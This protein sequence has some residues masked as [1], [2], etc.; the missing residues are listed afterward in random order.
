MSIIRTVLNE[1]ALITSFATFGQIEEV[2]N[3]LTNLFTY[4]VDMTAGIFTSRQ[5]YI[6]HSYNDNGNDEDR[7]IHFVRDHLDPNNSALF[8]YDKSNGNFRLTNG[9]KN[10]DLPLYMGQ[11]TASVHAVRLDQMP[12][13]MRPYNQSSPPVRVDATTYSMTTVKVPAHD[14][15]Y[16]LQASNLNANI[17]NVGAG[18][19]ASTTTLAEGLNVHLY[20]IAKSNGADPVLFWSHRDTDNGENLDGLPA[21]YNSIKYHKLP[22]SLRVNASNQLPAVNASKGWPWAP[23]L[24]F[25]EELPRLIDQGN[26]TNSASP[27]NGDLTDV[28]PGNA[29]SVF[30]EIE[31]WSNE[32]STHTAFIRTSDFEDWISALST[33]GAGGTDIN[34]NGSARV[35]PVPAN[36]LLEYYVNDTNLRF[37]ASIVSYTL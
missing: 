7:E 28:I 8:M 17:A 3:R 18:G 33:R 21:G 2:Q 23:E 30:L 5:I 36:G 10:F 34:W 15:T 16:F 32:A 12:A 31:T 26:S 6:A 20:V 13:L 24:I 1:I 22:F 35:I 27:A 11:G 14:F 29:K 4:A 9:A 25:T 37:S 19:R